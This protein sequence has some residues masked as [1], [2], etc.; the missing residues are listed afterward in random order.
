MNSSDTQEPCVGIFWFFDGRLLVDST[1]VSEAE[2]YG[3][4][5]T[6][7][8]SHIDYWERL[9]RTGRVP[10]DVPY[11][12]PAR[13]RIVYDGREQRFRLLADQCILVRRDV[14]RAIMKAMRLPP[15]KTTEGRDEHYRCFG[16][17]FPADDDD[18]F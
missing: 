11:E 17:L 12:E 16:C 7:A 8:T 10:S 6:H 13:G 3:T 4:A 15:G 5:M 14:V 2:P 18:E 9:Q 1:P